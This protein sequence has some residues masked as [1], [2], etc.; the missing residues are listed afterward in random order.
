MRNVLLW[1]FFAG[2]NAFGTGG[3]AKAQT[4]MRECNAH[5]RFGRMIVAA[6]AVKPNEREAFLKRRQGWGE[7]V[8]IADSELLGMKLVSSDEAVCWVRVAWY[9]ASDGELRTTTIRQTWREKK[10]SEDWELTAENREGGDIGLLGENVEVLRP[11]EPRAHAQFPTVR[12]G[13]SD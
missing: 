11:T 8:Q 10:M 6:E 5:A 3:A 4:A 7:I 2:C 12:I 1:L 9:R 13:A